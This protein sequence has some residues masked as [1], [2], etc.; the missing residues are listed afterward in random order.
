MSLSHVLLTN[1]AEQEKREEISV[2]DNENNQLRFPM[3]Y[4]SLSFRN[5]ERFKGAE[6]GEGELKENAIQL[7]VTREVNGTSILVSVTSIHTAHNST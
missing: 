4:F 7:N 3:S 5:N 6:R 1:V 2:R